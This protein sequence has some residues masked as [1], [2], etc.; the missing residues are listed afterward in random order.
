LDRLKHSDGWLPFKWW[1]ETF[2]RVACE[3]LY[4]IPEHPHFSPL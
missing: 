2:R 4:S 3:P 1:S